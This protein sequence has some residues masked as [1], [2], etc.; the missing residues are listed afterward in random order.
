MAAP[1]TSRPACLSDC[2]FSPWGP[3]YRVYGVPVEVRC[4]VHTQPAGKN[5]ATPAFSPSC[6]GDAAA[7]ADGAAAASD[8]HAGGASVSALRRPPATA[9]AHLAV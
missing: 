8:A 9:C 6:S 1:S 5:G 7:A 4:A 3:L 2:A